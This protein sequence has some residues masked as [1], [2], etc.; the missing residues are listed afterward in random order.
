MHEVCLAFDFALAR[1]GNNMAAKMA[2]MAITTRSSIN[3]NAAR[4][5]ERTKPGTA[6]EIVRLALTTSRGFVSGF[7]SL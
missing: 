2:M 4:V 6:V 1:A 5:F 7:I 3:V